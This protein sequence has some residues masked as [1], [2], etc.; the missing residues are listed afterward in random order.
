MYRVVTIILISL[1]PVHYLFAQIDSIPTSDILVEDL[2]QIGVES[3]Q[4]D[5][6]TLFEQLEN[7][8][9]NP[10]DLN[11]ANREEL[12]DLKLLSDI[13]IDRLLQYREDN[14]NLISIYE[15][16]AVPGF[17]L[18][19]I[20]AIL[21]YVRAG[22]A[23][24]DFHQPLGKMLIQGDN[25]LFL[26]WTT[27]LE[28]LD[29]QTNPDPAKQFLGDANRYYVRYRHSFEN[30]LYY[31]ITAEKDP[32]EA[33]FGPSNPGGFDYYS[34]HFYL[35]NYRNW[36]PDL[37]IGDYRVSMG[38]GLIAYSGFGYGKSADAVRILRPS[39]PLG[40]YSSV[41]EFD[42]FRGAALR[43]RP[44]SNLEITLFASLNNQ[45]AR[46]DDT[47]FQNDIVSSL[48]IT[49][50][51]RTEA[52]ASLKGNVIE[53]A[54]GGSVKWKGKRFHVAYN[55]IHSSLSAPLQRSTQL[56][57]Q[58]YFQGSSLLNTSV[59]Y[60]WRW[61]GIHV[62]GE[63]A[64]DGNGGLAT[65]NGL[66]VAV[67]RE[68]DLA[69]LY[70]NF[71]A[72]FQTLHGN[73]FAESRETRNENGIY[74]GMTW[75]PAKGWILNGYYDL[76]RHPWLRYLIDA[77]SRGSDWLIRLERFKKRTWRIYLQFR[78]EKKEFNVSNNEGKTD[79]ISEGIT[80]SSRLHFEYKVSPSLEFRSRIGWNTYTPAQGD[81]T[82]GWMMYQD[83]IFKPKSFPL[84][85]T[86]RY[87]LFETDDYNTR[88]YNFEN[89]LLY[90][91]SIPA[92]YDRGSRMYLNMRYH[93]T[94]DLTLEFRIAR[95]FLPT[96]TE[97]GSGPYLVEGPKRTEIKAQASF[98]F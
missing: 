30:R 92:Y 73:A 54:K 80:F 48:L 60:D 23:L 69:L 10:L 40:P 63:T 16:Q 24:D 6:N 35:R 61:K 41:N 4:L 95:L 25:K 56:Y 74:T 39:R 51:H 64:L 33:F 59:D 98:S 53:F 13:Q 50:F 43:L 37:A 52:E 85:F 15:L 78:G 72:E 27:N 71:S 14:G 66:L 83:V 75:R 77:P 96:R 65:S 45:D 31:G 18:E 90:V 1:V 38:Q 44:I 94:S 57:N 76:Y 91:F 22:G 81:Q 8:R 19:T 12:E 32:G 34:A 11:Q 29:G 36:L 2:I 79:V 7:Y 28:A 89:D 3:S 5:H 84:S 86:A 9:K 17:E 21:P 67:S 62:F 46:V 47:T 88:F 93:A 49:G 82:Q 42:F 58:F 70:R 87:A 55:L 26:R 68:L 97:L 20:R